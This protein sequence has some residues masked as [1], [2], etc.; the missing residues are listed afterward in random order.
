MIYKNIIK[1]YCE[2]LQKNDIATAIN[3]F[4]KNA[5]IISPTLGTQTIEE[6]L[7]FI[8]KT[9]R[10]NVTINELFT[11]QLNHKRIAAYI[12]VTSLWQNVHKVQIDAIDIFEFDENNKIKRVEMY[13][14]S[15][16][17]RGF[18]ENL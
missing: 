3:L 6:F 9:K 14:D 2:L 1:Q 15:Y 10:T 11:S 8:D 4:T 5:Q 13:Y 7:A 16:A 17:M 12:T 18:L